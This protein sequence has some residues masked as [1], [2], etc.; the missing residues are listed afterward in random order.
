MTELVAGDVENL[1]T[2]VLETV[3]HCLEVLILGCETATRSGVDDE[4]NLALIL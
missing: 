4:Q 2:L 1:Q 3:I